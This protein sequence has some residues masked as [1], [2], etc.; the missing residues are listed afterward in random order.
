MKTLALLLLLAP[1]LL[2]REA[3]T[4][5]D[6]ARFLAGLPLPARSPLAAAANSAA[7]KAHAAEM[8]AAWIKSESRALAKTRDWAATFVRGGGAPCYY[9]FSGPDILY[10]HTIFPGAP[11]YVLCATEPIGSVPDFASSGAEPALAS[12]RQSLSNVLRFSYF[13]TKDMRADLGGS[14]LSGVLPIFYV[15]LARSGCTIQSV[16]RMSAGAP[17]VRI[18]FKSGFGTHTMY[19]FQADLSNGGSGAAVMN[20]CRKQGRGVGLLKAASY[21]LHEESFSR[22]RDFLLTDCRVLVQDDSGIPN[23]YFA[24]DRWQVR[25]FGHY[26][27]TTGG[28]FA[29]Y[30]QA[31]LAAA[32]EQVQTADLDFSL[33]YQWNPKTANIVV[34]T[35]TAAPKAAPAAPAK[36]ATAPAAP[37]KKHRRKTSS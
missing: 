7:W 13:I 9:M 25:F 5:N 6:Q 32:Y 30:H 2:A 10:A 24:R 8:D 20:F 17:G 27:G 16:E 12:V 4:V 28:I 18:V 23:R 36:K 31:D 11:V 1:A 3:V 15:L 14:H 19:Y 29:K 34:A 37:A 21:L 26:T 33:S 35:Q 22:C